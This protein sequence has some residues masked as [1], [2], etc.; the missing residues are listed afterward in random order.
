MRDGVLGGFSGF[1]RSRGNDRL[2]NILCLF[3]FVFRCSFS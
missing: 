3:F 1:G 2:L